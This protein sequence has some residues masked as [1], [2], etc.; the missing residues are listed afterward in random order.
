MGCCPSWLVG[1]SKRAAH[2]KLDGVRDV[3][4]AADDDEEEWDDFEQVGM[5]AVVVSP[6]PRSLY[7]LDDDEPK[8]VPPPAGDEL[9][10]FKDMT[11]V[12]QRVKKHATKQA[13]MPSHHASVW[14]ADDRPAGSSAFAM[15]SLGMD[16][17]DSASGWNED[18]LSTSELNAETRKAREARRASGAPVKK[19]QATRL[20]GV[21]DI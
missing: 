6:R 19:L 9:D 12:I 21:K 10:P 20:P 16:A 11:P 4:A 15:D 14:D 18:G 2:H 8:R 17:R 5:Q 13:G 3:E 7:G 1:G